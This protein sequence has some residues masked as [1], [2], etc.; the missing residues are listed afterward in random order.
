MGRGGQL[1]G[2]I[3]EPV[4]V[5]PRV[6][7]GQRLFRQTLPASLQVGIAG[8][9]A[10]PFE[11]SAAADGQGGLFVQVVG[12]GAGREQVVRLV[13][14]DQVEVDLKPASVPA[15]Q[16]VE[17][18]ESTPVFLCHA[19]EIPL[20]I[21]HARL[22]GGGFLLEYR[23]VG[24]VRLPQ[25]QGD[26]LFGDARFLGG[27]LGDGV[28]QQVG[29]LQSDVGDHAHERQQDVGGV[30]PPAQ[31]RLDHGD[32]HVALREVVEGQRGGHLE[33]REFQLL[34]A[35]AVLVHEIDHF[36]FGNHLP[37]DAD[38]LA[39]VVQVGRGVEPR[40][41]AG[42]LQH[43]GEDVRHGAFAVGACDVD[44]EEVALRIAQVTAERGDAFE[45]R[46]I[47]LCALLLKGGERRVEE[48][49]GLGIV[50]RWDV[51]VPDGCGGGC[52]RP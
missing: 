13:T 46:F 21:D 26:A 22:E 52:G 36:L 38:A 8:R 44:G 16:D 9:I 19:G 7:D 50:H 6:A 31:P 14:P 25:N 49:E 40:A 5:V 48:F 35:V 43:R 24:L 27:D 51:K 3:A 29:V 41:V 17:T 30:E 45:T 28:P 11:E 42:L 4:G 39:E 2:H 12:G 34:H 1:L 20:G 37:V 32:L 23:V 18:L 33:E 47:G 10:G 15:A